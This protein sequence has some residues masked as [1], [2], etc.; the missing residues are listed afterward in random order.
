MILRNSVIL[1]FW[2]KNRIIT[3]MMNDCV[4]EKLKEQIKIREEDYKKGLAWKEGN[5]HLGNNKNRSL[6]GLKSL[7]R[8]LKR[9]SEIYKAYN[10]VKQ[11]Q[12][13]QL[14]KMNQFQL[15]EFPIAKSSIFPWPSFKPVIQK[16]AG[17]KRLWVV[18]DASAKYDIAAKMKSSVTDFFSEC[19]QIR[20][21]LRIWSHLLKK[22][23]MKN[24]IFCSVW[25][26]FFIGWLKISRGMN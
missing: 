10:S 19:D 5:L 21:K 14:K 15:T 3:T 8:D 4:Y 6:G 18:Y 22:S 16:I 12:E 23:L 26:K 20:K 17:S 7:V 25:D 2:D 1:V 24:F 13:Q 11:E 9:N